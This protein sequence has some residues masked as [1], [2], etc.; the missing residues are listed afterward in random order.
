MT[1][2]R[3]FLLR[4]AAVLC[5]GVALA[6]TPV[7]PRLPPAMNAAEIEHGLHRLSVL[8]RVLYVAAHPDDENT[9]LI[10]WL[11]NSAKLDVAYLS[12][13]RGDGGQNLIGSELREALGLIRTHELLAARRVD[14]GRQ[15]FTRANDFG[16]SK[17]PEETM[18]IWDRDKILA[19]TVWT[20]RRFRPDVIVTRFSPEYRDTHGH[21]MA[22]A[23][24]AVEAFTA[25]ADPQRYPEQLKY[26]QPWKAR[27]IVWN[28]SQFF[29][30]A[31]RQPFNAADYLSFDA[32]GFDPLLGRAYGEISAASRSMHK[33]QGFGMSVSRGERKEY[34]KLLAGEPGEKTP[35]DGVDTT[36][37]R[38]PGAS[39]IAAQIEALQKSFQPRKPAAS[40]PG[41]LA[42]RKAL[43]KLP[44]EA[45][46]AAKLVEVER[47]IAACLGLHLEAVATRATA[48]P[49]QELA[50]ALEGISQAGVN[51]TWKSA[52][53]RATGETLTLDTALTAASLFK[54]ELNVKLPA[55]LPITQPYWLQKPG[56]DGTFEVAD[57][58][59]IGTPENAPA[60]AYDAVVA[61]EGEELSFELPV[62]QRRNDRVEGE[63]R[64]PLVIA[65][66]VVAAFAHPFLVFPK[67]EPRKVAVR[68]QATSGA[69]QGELAL[70][71][72]AGWKV[73]PAS[74]P[75]AL[76]TQSD[77]LGFEFTVTPP[78]GTS[79]G[80]LR[81]VTSVGG[82]KDS[83]ARQRIHYPHIGT[84][85]LL[86]PAETR[87][88]RV[89]VQVTARKIGYI[90]GAGDDIP[91]GLEQLGCTVATLA[92]ADIQA[93]ALAQ[94]DAV[95]LGVR[96]FNTSDRSPAWL[97]ELSAYAAKG[98]VVVVQ[99]HTTDLKVRE[100]GP[101]PIKLSRER[102]TDETAEVRILQPPHPV[103]LGPNN[104]GPDDFKGWVQER[105][106]YF[107]GSWDP[108]WRPVFS[109]NDPG[110]NG[111][112]GG[113]L[114][115]RTG[116]G[117]FVYTGLA[118]F[119]QFPAGVPGSYR[120]FAN[121]VSL[122]K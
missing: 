111:L 41:L 31:S 78:A 37:A 93:G 30:Q 60:I 87:L 103:V 66:P 70:E 34:F 65:P 32:G 83:Y 96:T 1:H 79:T 40:V 97:A 19:D 15:F 68:L 21:H 55:D 11:S 5:A 89:D 6:D 117:Y 27:R 20:I 88:A 81:A 28:T 26:V 39:G 77:E 43:R 116:N 76:K 107:A 62:R 110:E 10:G 108:A 51:V 85:T 101:L 102:V 17:N 104:L 75:F 84:L 98:G 121:L 58:Q 14:G 63:V 57:Q 69:A 118:F 47:L 64:E 105:G 23:I 91:A 94:F 95:V 42:L 90:P 38:V 33:S 80:Q 12:L 112:E 24:L 119:R 82:R 4:A 49:G 113:L 44:A 45:Y 25:A 71:A 50:I 74:L 8:G 92:D 7:P 22:S 52:R 106:L 29:F 114:V 109:L 48:S 67:A 9:S 99:Y 53:N 54:K 100:V 61:I 36:W 35:L 120:L 122:G 13:T 18:R 115:A 16:Y 59:L 2:P 56:T 86:P 73:E 3:G 46:T 72:P